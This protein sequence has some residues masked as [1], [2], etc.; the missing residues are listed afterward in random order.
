MEAIK[1]AFVDLVSCCK[2]SQVPDAFK[3][4]T[5]DCYLSWILSKIRLLGSGETTGLHYGHA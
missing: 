1:V 3:G 4:H 2:P 5:A